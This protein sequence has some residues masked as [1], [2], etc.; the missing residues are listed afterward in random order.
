MGGIGVV[1]WWTLVMA[2]VVVLVVVVK[3]H[4]PLLLSFSEFSSIHLRFFQG[5]FSLAFGA[6]LLELRC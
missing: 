5:R 6:M 1:L 3:V 4:P 2:V